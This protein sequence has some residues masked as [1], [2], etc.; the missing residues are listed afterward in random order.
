MSGRLICLASYPKSGNTW[1]RAM[2]LAYVRRDTALDINAMSIDIHAS[3]RAWIDA[4]SGLRSA[5]FPED[6]ALLIRRATLT[7]LGAQPG[8]LLFLKTH[9]ANLPL[10]DGR[11]RFEP[12]AVRLA[13][14]PLRHPYDVAVSLSHHMGRVDDLAGVV[15]MM[16]DPDAYFVQNQGARFPQLLSDWSGNIRSWT[17][18]IPTA[19]VIRYEDMLADPLPILRDVVARCWPDIPPDEAALESACAQT[20]FTRLQAQEDEHAF[21]E[22]PPASAR[23]FREGRAGGGAALPPA[24]RAQLWQAHHQVMTEYGYR[25]DGTTGPRP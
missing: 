4:R 14:C 22:R 11:P 3:T 15:A 9:D 6:E 19:H 12:E 20:S 21:H 7:T 1:L 16:C 2:L 18:S 17:G 23:F 24:L 5:D 13:L 25:E 8:D 10:A